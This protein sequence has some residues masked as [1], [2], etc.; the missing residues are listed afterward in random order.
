MTIL[1]ATERGDLAE[2]MLRVAGQLACLVHGDGDVDAIDALTGPL[3]RAELVGLA[4]ALAGLVDPDR[5]LAD[6]LDF[7][8]WDEHGAPLPAART[9][10]SARTIRDFVTPRESPGRPAPIRA[11]GAA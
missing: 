9:F 5:P 1:T 8:T 6:A 3:D 11:T 10:R 2:R 4:V 7:L